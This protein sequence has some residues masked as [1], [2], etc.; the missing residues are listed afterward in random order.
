MKNKLSKSKG[1]ASLFWARLFA[2]SFLFFFLLLSVAFALETDSART[3]NQTPGTSVQYNLKPGDVLTHLQNLD[4]LV[5]LEDNSEAKFR[6]SLTWLVKTAVISAGAGEIKLASQYN[7]QERKI[8][9]QEELEKVLGKQETD[10][11]L[12]PYNSLSPY[13]SR[14]FTIDRYGKILDNS[15]N[16]IQSLSFVN[17]LMTKIM[18]LP[19]SP[20]EAGQSYTI[21]EEGDEL[22]VTF[23]GIMNRPPYELYSF[24][25]G[26][27][28]GLVLYLFNKQLGVPDKLEYSARY[29]AA[30]QAREEKFSLL[31]LEKKHSNS[32]ELFADQEVR[33][34]L[35]KAALQTRGLTVPAGLVKELLSS[36]YPDQ[37]ILGSAVCALK[38]IPEGLDLKPFL[39]HKNPVVRFDLAKALYLFQKNSDPMKKLTEDSDSYLRFRAKNFLEN[40]DYV[41]TANQKATLN[42]LRRWFY[43]KD[44][45]VLPELSGCPWPELHRLMAALKPESSRLSGFFKFFLSEEL[46]DLKRPYYVYLPDDYDPAEKFPLIIYLGMGEGRGD[47]ALLSFYNAL[48]KDNSLAKYILVV[49]Q[50]YGLW[51]DSSV[52]NNLKRIWRQVFQKFSLDTN[53]VFLAGSS[54]GGIATYYYA[55]SFPDRLA[56]MAESMGYPMLDRQN[57]D[58]T[59]DLEKLGN[60]L[61][62]KVFLSHGLDDE[63]ITPEGDLRAYEYLKKNKTEVRFKGLK[64][65]KHNVEPAEIISLVREIFDQSSRNPYPKNIYFLATEPDYLQCYWI[66]ILEYEALPAEVKSSVSDNEINL[67]TSQVKNLRLYLDEALVDFNRPVIIKLND[68]VVFEGYVQPSTS[69][70]LLSVREKADPAMSYCSFVDLKTD[71]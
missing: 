62:T 19:S 12:L 67:T 23:N 47:I 63:H 24:A 38:G 58:L 52:E 26:H 17:S 7:L 55:S 43:L 32:A 40:S 37:Q 69:Q 65:K 35:V 10:N 53:R 42:K 45:S 22:R 36:P 44:D 33:L 70:L 29:R 4:L 14:L 21:G 31:F 13:F 54:N 59:E 30:G 5:S 68:Q 64:G 28:S 51:W 41:L 34:A 9:G 56:A 39:K 49:P 66:K 57:F 20:L 1:P 6:V 71:H 48:Q 3:E 25:G 11:L 15:F 27:P 50:A 60:L 46:E 8:Y 18:A 16:F 2:I 61:N